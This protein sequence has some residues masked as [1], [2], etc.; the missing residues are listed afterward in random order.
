MNADFISYLRKM[1]HSLKNT[2]RHLRTAADYLDKVW[3]IARAASFTGFASL[4]GGVAVGVGGIVIALTGGAAA[5]QVVAG[6]AF[7]GA[8]IA[9]DV[10][11]QKVNSAIQSSEVKK[12]DD[13]VENTKRVINDVRERIPDVQDQVKF[14]VGQI[15]MELDSIQRAIN[16]LLERTFTV[17]SQS[18]IMVVFNVIQVIKDRESKAAQCFREKAQEIEI[19]LQRYLSGV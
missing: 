6:L 17:E 13:N 5:P 12:P 16:E 11:A 2:I 19:V 1:M 8:E 18:G 9:T 3:K 7:S 15:V 14:L 10:L 4:A